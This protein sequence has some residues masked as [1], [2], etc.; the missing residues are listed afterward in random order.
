ML[1]RGPH[2]GIKEIV[3]DFFLFW[4]GAEGGLDLRQ[5]WKGFGIV[6]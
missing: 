5:H 6:T 4:L 3:G 1:L 2:Q